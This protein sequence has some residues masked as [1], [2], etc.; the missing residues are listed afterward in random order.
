MQKILLNV[1][2]SDDTGKYWQDSYIKNEVVSF[3]GGDVHQRV[4]EIMEDIDGVEFSY[5]G[6]PKANIYIDDKDG[7]PKAV[8]Y[9]Y[10]VK[11]DLYNQDTGKTERAFFDAWVEIKTVSDFEIEL[12]D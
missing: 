12:I 10:R 8:G 11:S 1:S 2:Y 5:K 4:I 6:K 7:N 3:D 9:I